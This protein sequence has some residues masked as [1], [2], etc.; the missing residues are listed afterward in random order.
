MSQPGPLCLIKNQKKKNINHSL[1][2]R[3]SRVL[4]NCQT[5]PSSYASKHHHLYDNA[6]HLKIFIFQMLIKLPQFRAEEKAVV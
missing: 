5:R 1:I 3:L 2:R 4:N 6:H